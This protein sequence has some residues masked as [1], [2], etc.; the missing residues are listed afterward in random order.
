MSRAQLLVGGLAVLALAACSGDAGP[1]IS[2]VPAANISQVI[3][4]PKATTMY[5]SDTL[6]ATDKLQMQAVV[7][8]RAG[9]PIATAAVAWTSLDP[10]VAL[11]DSTGVVV[12][13]GFGTARIVGSAAKA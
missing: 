1:N 2:G 5:V 6:R 10:S 13:R 11:V 4:S 3:V 8:N 12:P 7:L 9:A